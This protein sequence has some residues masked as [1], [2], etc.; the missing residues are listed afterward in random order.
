MGSRRSPRWQRSGIVEYCESIRFVYAFIT[1][2]LAVYAK[3]KRV[4]GDEH[5]SLWRELG[6]TRGVANPVID[7]SRRRW[8]LFVAVFLAETT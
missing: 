6:E 2:P 5:D 3:V 1:G 8:S 7:S 4:R